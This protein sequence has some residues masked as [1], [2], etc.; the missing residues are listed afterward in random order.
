[1]AI[2]FFGTVKAEMAL[3]AVLMVVQDNPLSCGVTRKSKT[4][5]KG[6]S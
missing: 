1:M 3:L 6:G 5:V 4:A 2:L